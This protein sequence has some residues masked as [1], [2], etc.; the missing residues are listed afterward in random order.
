MGRVEVLLH[1]W[2]EEEAIERVSAKNVAN[3]PN[4]E[5]NINGLK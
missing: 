1:A 5:S 4:S 2:P 3:P